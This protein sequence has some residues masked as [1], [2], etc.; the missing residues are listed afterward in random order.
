MVLRE[1]TALNGLSGNEAEV[2]E[3]IIKKAKALADEVRVDRIGNVIA[4][5][6]GMD[7]SLGR[8]MVCAHMDEVGLMAM[9]VDEEGFIHY[10]TV[11]GVEP[12]VVISKRVRFVRSGISGVIGA[13]AIHLQTDDELAS[14]LKHDKLFIDIGA[15]DKKQ[16]EESVN[17]G[18]YI[19]FESDWVEFGDNLVKVKALDDR[20]GCYNM[21]RLMENKYPMDVAFAFTVQ[22][23]VG[24]RGAKVA[25]YQVAPRFCLVLEGTTANDLGDVPEHLRV[26][27]VGQGV[28]I[29]FMDRTSIAHPALA[30]ALRDTAKANNI[31]W[32]FKT[33]VSGGNDAGEVQYARGAIPVC[34]LSVPCRY[35]HSPSS[36]CSFKDIEAQYELVNA[37][38]K[39]GAAFEEA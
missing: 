38:L 25:A 28:A 18:D 9:G 2:R 34:P 11:G 13:K 20:V 23:E 5:K 35:I 37:F 15:K 36:V 26:T 21:L 14:P 1:L 6:K 8:A 29:S 12:S 39:S 19:A 30:R 17:A 24:L 22:E 7:S 32:Q 16:A 27:R 33:F 4:T 10:D 3:Y 31:P